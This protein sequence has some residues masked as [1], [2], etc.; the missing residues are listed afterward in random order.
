MLAELWFSSNPSRIPT[1]VCVMAILI[2]SLRVMYNINGQGIWEVCLPH[3]L[4]LSNSSKLFDKCIWPE[5]T[6]LCRRFARKEETQLYLI[7]MQI[8]QLSESMRPVTV[9][10]LSREN[11]CVLSQLPMIKLM[12]HMVNSNGHCLVSTLCLSCSTPVS[13]WHAYPDCR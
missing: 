12:W 11:Y 8:Q 2:V 10:S 7:M 3:R 4:P 13:L 9:M 6:F 5:V 1:R